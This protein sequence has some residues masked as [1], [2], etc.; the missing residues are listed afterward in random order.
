MEE[1]DKQTYVHIM[2][3]RLFLG[4]HEN[5]FLRVDE[6]MYM[7]KSMDIGGE[8]YRPTFHYNVVYCISRPLPHL[9]S[10]HITFLWLLSFEV[11]AEQSGG[12]N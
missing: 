6:T 12:S 7:Y 2:T 3:I 9:K 1:Q 5:R 4:W 10:N 8:P 11:S